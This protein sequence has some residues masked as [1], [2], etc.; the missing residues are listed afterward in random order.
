ML[1]RL[2]SKRAIYSNDAVRGWL[3]WGALAPLLAV[4]LVVAPLETVFA[5]LSRLHLVDA[6]D[7]PVGALGFYA[8]LLFPFAALGLVVLAWAR[9][10]E[11]RSL[12]TLGLVSFER[13]TTFLRGHLLGMAMV[14]VVVAGIWLAGGFVESGFGRALRWPSGLMNASLL[15]V[16]FAVQSSV[17]EIFFRGWLLSA[18]A[19]KFGVPLAVGLSSLVFTF[20]HYEGAGQPWLFT[21]NTLLF[22]LFACVWALRAGSVWGVMGFHSSWNWLFATGF[23]VRVTGLDAHVPAL[24]AKMIPQGPDYLTGGPQGPEG[25]FVCSLVLVGAIGLAGWRARRS[26][27]V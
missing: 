19:Y 6:R 16:C 26:P 8:F 21:V 25:S 9:F 18:I 12:A 15:L 1:E 11:R 3:P 27:R 4:V 5:V 24:I 13:T 7:E 23:E 17:E 14:C 2:T 22:A 10:V 20:L